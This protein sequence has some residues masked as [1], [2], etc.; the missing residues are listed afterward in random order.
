MIDIIPGGNVYPWFNQGGASSLG[1]RASGMSIM[2]GSPSKEDAA[3]A[4]GPEDTATVG[5]AANLWTAGLVFVVLLILLHFV[6]RQ[7][8]E[9]GEFKSIKVSAYNAFVIGLAAVVT[10]PVFKYLAS[11]QPIGSIKAW[12]KAA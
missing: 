4:P 7:F 3:S 12:V 11:K 9:E 6:G 2:P 10:L 1:N 5:G 8:G